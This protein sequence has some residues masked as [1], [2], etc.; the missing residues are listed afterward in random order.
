MKDRTE[1]TVD[2]VAGLLMTGGEVLHVSSLA[3]RKLWWGTRSEYQGSGLDAYGESVERF[4][5]LPVRNIGATWD[6]ANNCA[7]VLLV[8]N[9]LYIEKQ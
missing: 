3:G 8:V 4:R 2:Q 7:A 1:I 5:S 6:P 9:D